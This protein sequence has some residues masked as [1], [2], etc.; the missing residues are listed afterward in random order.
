MC[1]FRSLKIAFLGE[2]VVGQKRL[3]C[4]HWRPAATQAKRR[5]NA[6]LLE[7]TLHVCEGLSEKG[8]GVTDRG[9]T[10]LKVLRVWRDFQRFSA[11][12]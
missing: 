6:E 4:K 12:F 2:S 11:N 10:A 1:F 8:R 7:I 9:V 3:L 5:V